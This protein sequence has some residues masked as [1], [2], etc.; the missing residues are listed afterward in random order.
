MT[1]SPTPPT[2]VDPNTIIQAQEAA[3]RVN[4]IT[5]FGTQTYDKNGNLT[6]TL[7][8]GT[9][10]AFDNTT[11]MA[12]NQ[13]QLSQ[14]PSGYGALEQTM[15]NKVMQQQ[16]GAGAGG[17]SGKGGQGAPPIGNIDGQQTNPAW[18]AALS[19]VWGGQ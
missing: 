14:N 8:A 3:N 17:A 7:P 1:G 13:Q 9:Q 16:G 11:A 4:R 6:T 5:P 19:K 2:P 10:K 18:Q 12:G 15:L